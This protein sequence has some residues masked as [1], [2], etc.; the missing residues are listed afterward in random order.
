[1]ENENFIKEIHHTRGDL[2]EMNYKLQ[3][4]E[5]KLREDALRQ[6]AQHLREERINLIKKKEELEL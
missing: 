3:Q 1:M 2:E 6:R 5:E 4:S